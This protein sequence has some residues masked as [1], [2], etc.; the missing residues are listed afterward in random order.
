M[1]NVDQS[2][3]CNKVRVLGFQTL[4]TTNS[5]SVKLLLFFAKKCFAQMQMVS[6]F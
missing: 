6:T 2:S 1:S 3:D 5:A 4:Q